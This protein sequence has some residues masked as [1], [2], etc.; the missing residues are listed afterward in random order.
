M[1]FKKPWITKKKKGRGQKRDQLR[2][3]PPH[4]YFIDTSK[5]NKIDF[6]FLKCAVTLQCFNKEWGILGK[7]I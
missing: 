4:V 7:I 2:L 3:N 1:S 5:C 6:N